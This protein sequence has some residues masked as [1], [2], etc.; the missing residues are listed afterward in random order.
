MGK[1]LLAKAH[2]TKWHGLTEY[3]V[4]EL[5]SSTVDKTAFAILKRQGS[6]GIT[7]VSSLSH[8]MFDMHVVPYWLEW[9]TKRSKLAA[10]DFETSEFHQDTWNPYLLLGLV[11][12][13]IPWNARS[14][15]ELQQSYMA[16]SNDLVLPSTTTLRN[17]GRREYAPTVNAIVKQLPLWNIVS[18]ALHGWTSTN[19]LATM[20]VIAYYRDRIGHCVKFISL[21]MGFIACSRMIGQR[22][23]YWSKVIRIFEGRAWSFWAYWRPFAWYDNW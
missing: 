10:N 23:S 13:H 3:E 16:I 11:W 1:H 4:T 5:T 21:S 12:A 20:L 6:W 18:L 17:I 22:P 9:Q 19:K 8:I 15:L 7:I 2:I 14:N